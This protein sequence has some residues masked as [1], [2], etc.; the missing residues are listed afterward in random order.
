MPTYQRLQQYAIAISIISIL[1]NGAEGAVSIAIGA[2]S[3]SRSLVFFGIQSGI[4]VAS[5]AIVVWRFR[6][7]A[8]PGEEDTIELSPVN[9][10]V[11]KLGTWGI[12]IL[13]AILALATE[14]TAIVG[15]VLHSEPDSSNASLIV[16][17]SA[18]VLMIIIWL[19]KR[20]LAVRLNS[21][22]MMGEA[23]CSLSCI[24]ITIVLFIGSLVFRL[25]HGGWWV[26]SATSLILGILFAREAWKMLSWVRDPEFNGGC[27]GG[28]ATN[29]PRIEKDAE[30][31]EQYRDLCECCY[32]KEECRK[33]DACKCSTS[34]EET[35]PCCVPKNPD[36]D[37]CCT[38]ELLQGARTQSQR[39]AKEIHQMPDGNGKDV[40]DT[41]CSK[42]EVI[43][44]DQ[45]SCC[46]VKV[47]NQTTEASSAS[48]T[49]KKQSSSCCQKGC[50]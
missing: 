27:C 36:G 7:I 16:A 3:S 4:E 38:H 45:D 33:A 19:P 14:V 29:G 42:D 23:T 25:W 47:I 39:N 2:E 20:T 9:L 40:V 37:L 12:G 31:V 1:Y 15:L 30:L 13:I 44:T 22:T 5:A 24:Q 6:H 17:A 28:C 11:E 18:L 26:D 8:K 35:L 32:E 49:N 41:C 50:C 10:R 48:E 21:S 34:S 46:N 43:P